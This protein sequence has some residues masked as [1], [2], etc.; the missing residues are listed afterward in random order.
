MENIKIKTPKGDGILAEI[1]KSELGYLMIKVEL[2]NKTFETFNIGKLNKN[3]SIDD[4]K[5]LIKWEILDIIGAI[6]KIG[7]FI[8]LTGLT[9]H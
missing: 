8:S 6:R 3:I 2:P 9:T 7:R 5:G 4:L 1:Y